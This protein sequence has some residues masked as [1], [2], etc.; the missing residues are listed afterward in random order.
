MSHGTWTSTIPERYRLFQLLPLYPSSIHYS[1]LST[2]AAISIS[3][4]G[5]MPNSLAFA[6]RRTHDVKSVLSMQAR[7]HSAQPPIRTRWQLHTS[8]VKFSYSTLWKAISKH[9]T[10]L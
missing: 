4:I 6:K 10:R 7:L 1:L 5:K 9:H 3:G 8:K 2:E